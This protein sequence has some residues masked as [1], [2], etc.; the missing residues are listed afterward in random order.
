VRIA[1]PAFAVLTLVILFCLPPIIP[2]ARAGP[3][4]VSGTLTGNTT[5][6]APGSPYILTGDVTVPAGIILTLDPGVQV[7][8]DTAPP[9]SHSIVVLGTIH[10][11]GR[12][13]LPIVFTSNDP[14][15]DRNDWV[16]IQFQ[17]S[18][19]CLV[20]RAQFSSGSTPLD[21]SHSSPKIANNSHPESGH[22][23]SPV[24]GPK[25]APLI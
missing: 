21:V 25:A 1:A 17:R 15:P 22:H 16:S 4:F 6:T 13:D 2:T 20:E 24:I 5:W 23:E 18:V 12:S 19:G 14:F 8:F 3:T 10:A 11:V 7:R 9:A